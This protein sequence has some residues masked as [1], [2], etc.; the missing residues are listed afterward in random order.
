MIYNWIS[1]R[2]H[3]VMGPFLH[4]LIW[5]GAVVIELC[6]APFAHPSQDGVLRA[7]NRN[8]ARTNIELLIPCCSLRLDGEL[9]EQFLFR[10]I[11]LLFSSRFCLSGQPYCERAGRRPVQQADS[12]GC[13]WLPGRLPS[14]IPAGYLHL[15]DGRRRSSRSH[16]LHIR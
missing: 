9:L 13:R 15:Q 4:L 11:R 14:A 12:S 16:L 2:A 8:N 6:K 10:A 1:E 3:R 7:A 5:L